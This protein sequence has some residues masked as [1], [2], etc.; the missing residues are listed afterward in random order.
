MWL[1]IDIP[2]KKV[3]LHEDGCLYIPKVDSKFKKLNGL[4][5]DGGWLPFK[6]KEESLIEYEHN[7]KGYE[8]GYCFTC[9]IRP[10]S[11]KNV[12]E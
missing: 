3:T 8:R 7:Y 4:L 1:N 10:E 5:R 11:K 6:N 12:S 2:T 9:V